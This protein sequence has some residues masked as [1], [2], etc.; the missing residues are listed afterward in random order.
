MHDTRP[1]HAAPA[2]PQGSIDALYDVVGAR[3]DVR[4]EFLPDAL[5]R[6]LLTRILNAAHMGPSV[7][8][9]QPWRFIMISDEGTRAKLAASFEA[10]NAAAMGTYSGERAATYASLKLSALQDAP[11][12]IAVTTEVDAKR[13]HGLGRASWPEMAQ[14]STVAA[15]QNLWLA[16]RVE[17]V[18]VG[19]VSILDKDDVR[20]ALGLPDGVAPTAILCVGYVKRFEPRPDLEAAGWEERLS[21]ADV[22]VAETY[23]GPSYVDE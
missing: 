7:G 8:L 5:P 23:D 17:G 16:A 12:L 3:R 18:G 20:D 2:M 1:D 9:M 4:R 19:W 21:L 14:F 13:G 10:A 15:I 11:T 6:A 22:V